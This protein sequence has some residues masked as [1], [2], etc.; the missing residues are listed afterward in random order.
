MDDFNDLENSS[1]EQLIEK[2]ELM[3]DEIDSLKKVFLSYSSHKDLFLYLI[4]HM[5]DDDNVLSNINFS[6]F[7][8]LNNCG[9][10]V[11][12]YP[13]EILPVSTAIL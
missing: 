10:S 2:V 9:I 3:Q 1:K 8:T 12:L 13:N 5:R 7:K 6:K 4:A 11:I